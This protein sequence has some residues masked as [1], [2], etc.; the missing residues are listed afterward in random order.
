MKFDFTTVKN[1]IEDSS[2]FKDVKYG[3]YCWRLSDK[4]KFNGFEN[5]SNNRILY[6]GKANKYIADRFYSNHLS[7]YANFSTFRRSIG[8]VLKKELSLEAIP[9]LRKDRSVSSYTNFSF[10]KNGEFKIDQW[11]I[12]N[13]EYGYIELKNNLDIQHK[14]FMISEEEKAKEITKPCLNCSNGDDKFNIYFSKIRDL[15]KVC[16]DEARKYKIN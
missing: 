7:N 4:S 15:R 6:T 5:D 9:R 2:Y 3:L 10:S 8:A 12:N 14:E 11:I 13:L 16:A 1:I